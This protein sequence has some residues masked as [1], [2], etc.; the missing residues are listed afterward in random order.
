M[1]DILIILAP[2]RED[3][4]FLLRNASSSHFSNSIDAGT[5]LKDMVYIYFDSI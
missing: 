2:K 1:I 5:A 4:F 3:M